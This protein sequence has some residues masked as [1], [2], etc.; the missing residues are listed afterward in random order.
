MLPKKNN[1]RL[2]QAKKQD[3]NQ[4]A[5][6]SPPPHTSMESSELAHNMVLLCLVS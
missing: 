6:L 3:S 2:D 1:V 5:I 4:Y